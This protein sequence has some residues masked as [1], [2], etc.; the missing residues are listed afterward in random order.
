MEVQGGV[1][2][3]QQPG[4]LGSSDEGVVILQECPEVLLL[5]ALGLIC[6][7]AERRPSALQVTDIP[8]E[9]PGK[10]C[11]HGEVH[12]KVTANSARVRNLELGKIGLEGAKPFPKVGFVGG[13]HDCS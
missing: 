5:E 8:A 7:A 9:N 11:G 3:L 4:S 12:G 1:H 6:H 10:H 2:G 13:S